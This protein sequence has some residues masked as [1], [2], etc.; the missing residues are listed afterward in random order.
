MDPPAMEALTVVT[1]DLY[2]E[3]KQDESKELY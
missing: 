3:M 2:K 1:A